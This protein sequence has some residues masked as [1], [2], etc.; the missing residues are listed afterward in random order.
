MFEKATK[1][2]SK[3]R[4]ALYGPSGSGKTYSALSIA[5]GLGQKI[6]V[7][8]TEYGSAS[9][10]ADL[11]DFD[12]CE[13]PNT[14]IDTYIKAIDFAS[15]QYDVIIIDSLTHAW[16]SLLDAVDKIA[17]TKYRGNSWSA[18]SDGTPQQRKLVDSLVR[19]QSHIIA[20]MR[21][22]TE[23]ITQTND[24]GRS[25]PMRVGLA[26]EQGKGIEYEFDFLASITPEHTLSFEKSRAHEF[27]DRIIE[28]PSKALGKELIAWLNA[29]TQATPQITPEQKSTLLKLIYQT[30]YQAKRDIDTLTE[31]EASQFITSLQSKV[32]ELEEIED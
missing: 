8:D 6:A 9:K 5:S 23:W 17:K 32:K 29:G 12:V 16:Q 22:K 25:A 3:L 20:T 10:Y 31:E 14:T 24:K 27:Q 26:P 18:W 28:K 21:A 11:F 30:G 13:L 2:K 15:S 19:C 4:M 7:I 1:Q